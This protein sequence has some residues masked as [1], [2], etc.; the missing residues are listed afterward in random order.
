MNIQ[1][2]IYTLSS[3]RKN[4]HILPIFGFLARKAES[5]IALISYCEYAMFETIFQSHIAKT[6]RKQLN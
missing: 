6:G 5:Y 4:D 3:G 2:T 1:R